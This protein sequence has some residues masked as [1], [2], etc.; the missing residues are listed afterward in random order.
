MWH[1]DWPEFSA[2]EG[3]FTVSAGLG[4]LV[5]FSL[6]PAA[7]PRWRGGVLFDDDVRDAMR[8]QNENDRDVFAHIGDATY[9]ASP[10]L[11]FVVDTL[12]VAYLGKR[13][14]KLA[15]NLGLVSLEAFAYSGFLSFAATQASARE[16][17]AITQCLS[18][19][20]GDTARCDLDSRTEAFWS[21]HTTIAAT[22]AGLVCANHLHVPLWGHPAADAL[23][24]A[25]ASANA[26]T[27]GMT[28]LIAD[29]HYATD[30][31]MGSAIGFGVGFAVPTLLHYGV[32][33]PANLAIAPTVSG[34][35]SGLAV[36]G[37]F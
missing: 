2:L 19:T 10:V 8:A 33:R 25:L 20:R 11:P 12:F 30:V 32:R 36:A 6:G 15:R 27:T 21:G 1:D 28:R 14:D 26:V 34:E 23:A 17:P 29:Q 5:L 22:S 31:L 3:V 9:Y 37:A 13:D 7:E 4:T 24:C 16:R 35:V 18:D